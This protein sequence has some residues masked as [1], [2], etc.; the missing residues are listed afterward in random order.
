MPT[1]RTQNE[2]IHHGTTCGEGR[3]CFRSTMRH[4]ICTNAS[5]GLSSTA[6]FLVPASDAR[7][8][9]D[10]WFTYCV[11]RYKILHT[12]WRFVRKQCK[13]EDA[14]VASGI[15]YLIQWRQHYLRAFQG[16]TDATGALCRGMPRNN[17]TSHSQNLYYTTQCKTSITASSVSGHYIERRMHAFSAF[18]S[19][20]AK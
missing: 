17:S 2:Q 3:T 4:Y 15:A 14:Y 6:E 5:S 7:S 18:L 20:F 11:C 12:N 10:S 19:L 16:T 1:P 9:T 13:L 8:L